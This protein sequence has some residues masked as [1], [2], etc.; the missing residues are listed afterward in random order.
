[1]LGSEHMTSE[2][3]PQLTDI[4]KVVLLAMARE[5]PKTGYDFHLG[6]KRERPGRRAIM[7]SGTWWKYVLPAMGP[8][9]LGLIAPVK[10]KSNLAAD[11]RGRRKDLLWLTEK[12]IVYS[13]YFG[14]SP[15]LIKTNARRLNLSSKGIDFLCDYASGLEDRGILLSVLAIPEGKI[16]PIP[17]DEKSFRAFANALDKH[18]ELKRTLGKLA[19]RRIGKFFESD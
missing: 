14:A 19:M 9:K 13:L 11:E 17:M 7:S 5:G 10:S 12:G 4:Q 8:E 16:P 15:E 1:M 2:P 18:P 6:G 3:M